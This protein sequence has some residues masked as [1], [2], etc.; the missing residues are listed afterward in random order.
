MG[1]SELS[2]IYFN[3]SYEVVAGTPR[4]HVL[5]RY[6]VFA[7]HPG[8]L[9]GVTDVVELFRRR[10]GDEPLVVRANDEG[11][12]Y[13]ANEVVMVL[14][15]PFG[16]LVT[17]ETECLGLLSLSGAAGTMAAIVEAAEGVPVIDMGARHF[18]PSLTAQLAM[19]AALGGASGT[20]TEAG[21]NAVHARY[22]IG[23][24]RI[25]IGER[26][27]QAFGLYGSIPHALNAVF[28]GNSIESAAA[29]HERHREVPLTVLLDF[30]GRE[31]DVCVEAVRRFGTALHAVRLDTPGERVHQ[32]GHA[33]PVRAL[34][35]RVLSGAA[36]RA[37]AEA[38]L[39]RYGF[40][41]GVT[42]EAVYGIRDLL[43][44]LGARETKIVVS[45]G[46]DLEKVRAFRACGAPMDVVGTG[47]WVRF[48]MFTSDIV[49]I[50]DNGEW[51]PR[52]KA[53]REWISV[54]ETLPLAVRMDR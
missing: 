51:V 22:G 3:R 40:G 28:E 11:E 46:F 48:E 6:A 7:R 39:R 45:S 17:L 20:S 44:S 50:F 23:G 52:V 42:I 31:R 21:Y 10:W 13:A 30:E 5:V 32:G 19:A 12:A 9:C 53:G 14:E 33:E 37:A 15:G 24:D 36:D 41:P 8:V 38:G 2:D 49:S 27:P 26:E 47:S 16:G 25:R 34:G 43:N 1:K 35:M 54:P 29:Y 18:P 4:E